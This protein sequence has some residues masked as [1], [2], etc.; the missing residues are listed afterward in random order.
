METDSYEDSL[1]ENS[2]SFPAQLPVE[3]SPEPQ[4]VAVKGSSPRENGDTS[5]V[6]STAYPHQQPSVAGDEVINENSFLKK[7]ELGLRNR[8]M[9]RSQKEALGTGVAPE[10]KPVAPNPEQGE[11]ENP[12]KRKICLSA[13]E[14]LELSRLNSISASF[15]FPDPWESSKESEGYFIDLLAV[16]R[17]GSADRRREIHNKINHHIY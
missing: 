12:Q 5:I 7:T 9:S 17:L 16:Q 6:T 8:S 3:Q 11:C 4:K 13:Q 10:K 14:K 2:S 15:N 1:D